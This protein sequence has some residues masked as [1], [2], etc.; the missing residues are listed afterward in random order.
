M[1]QTPLLFYNNVGS[2]EDWGYRVQPQDGFC[3]GYKENRCTWPRGK[4]LGGCSSINA[5]FYVRGNKIDYDEWAAAGNPGWSYDEVLKYFMK[6]QNFSNELTDDI[7]KYH[8]TGGYLNVENDPEI[9]F[10][11][12]VLIQANNELGLKTLSDVN[13]DSQIGVGKA[14]CT[15]KNGVRQSTARAFLTPIKDR[16][17]FHVIKNAY[18]TKIMFKPNTNV[19]TGIV[20]HK[21]GREIKVNANKEVIISAGAINTPQLLLLSG[22]GPL[23][24]LQDLNIDVKADLPVGEN[25][26]DHVFVP[27]YFTFPGDKNLTSLESISKEFTTFITKQK[28]AFA[29]ISPHRIIAFYNTTDASSPSPDVQFHFLVFPPGLFNLVDIL[30]KHKLSDEVQMKYRKLNEDNFILIIYVVVLRPKSRGRILLKSKDPYEHP[31]IYAHY[32]EDQEDFQTMMRG[33]KQHILRF[34]DTKT[35]KEL[36]LKMNWLDLESC[37]KHEKDT[38]DFLECYTRHMTFSLYHPTSTAKMGPLHEKDTVV[39]PELR[40]K[41]IERL[42]VID[43]SVMPNIVRGNTNAPTIM[44]GEKGADMIKN[45]WL[46]GHTEL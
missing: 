11:E 30:A 22:I 10:F 20:I 28:G 21:N 24:Q 16:K 25:L 43:A 9:H 33:I 14:F 39:D 13:G 2:P 18:A 36:G 32:F 12:K 35:F 23:N 6:S 1:F 19:A 3:R 26:Q 44:I 38:D 31:L 37:K 41:N 8:G 15:I 17:N 29:N 40:V 42:R 4:V 27:F 7:K 46:K 5:M 45:A 34:R